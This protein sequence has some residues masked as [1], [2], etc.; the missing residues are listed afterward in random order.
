M[1]PYVL[2]LKILSNS[3]ARLKPRPEIEENFSIPDIRLHRIIIFPYTFHIIK[4]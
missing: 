3:W 2:N 4:I 1:Q